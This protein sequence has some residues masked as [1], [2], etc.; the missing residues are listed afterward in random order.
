MIIWGSLEVIK[1]EPMEFR[2]ETDRSFEP[3]PGD[4]IWRSDFTFQSMDLTSL[5][6]EAKPGQ[7]FLFRHYLWSCVTLSRII[8]NS[9]DG[10]GIVSAG[11]M[12]SNL[13]IFQGH[14][15]PCFA[16]LF[17]NCTKSWMPQLGSMLIPIL[18][19][20]IC[21]SI[22]VP[23]SSKFLQYTNLYSAFVVTSVVLIKY[24]SRVWVYY[25]FPFQVDWS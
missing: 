15:N 8:N 18:G 20:V 6:P 5:A 1:I 24:R 25:V 21:K 16:S 10:W 14:I 3:K 2:S 9:W 23:W 22:A 13:G 11:D 17:D 12:G 7:T 4:G 19:I